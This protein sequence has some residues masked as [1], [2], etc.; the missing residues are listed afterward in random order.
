MPRGR[1][2]ACGSKID[3]FFGKS[4]IVPWRNVFT[5]SLNYRVNYSLFKTQQNINTLVPFNRM[6]E[7][8]DRH[9]VPIVFISIPFYFSSWSLTWREKRERGQSACEKA[10][11][12]TRWPRHH[13][14]QHC[15]FLRYC[16]LQI[17]F[18]NCEWSARVV[19]AF[20]LKY[21]L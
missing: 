13:L 11:E 15:L 3:F 17:S 7:I 18:E 21:R 8:S 9:V 10:R 14:L 1:L 20:A 16:F 19:G 2:L 6:P 12:L 4:W 5:G